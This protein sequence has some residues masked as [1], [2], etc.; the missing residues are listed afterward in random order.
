[1]VLKKKNIIFSVVLFTF[2]VSV[3]FILVWNGVILLNNPSKDKYPV[4]GV[5]VSSYQGKIDWQVLSSQN[6][7]FAFIKATEGSTFVD[8]C[9]A[10]NY[11]EAMKTDLRIGAY[12]FFSFD[13]PGE[14][15]ADNFMATVPITEHML[16]PVVDFEF[17]V[18][19]E[20]NPPEAKAV[21]AQLDDLLEKLETH[22][23]L[24]PILYATDKS[25][26]LYLSGY[27][28]DYDIWIRNVI[29]SASLPDSREWTFWQFTDREKL[30][31]YSGEEK[32]I[33]V[34][35]FYGTVQDFE[36]YAK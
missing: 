26:S 23:G 33:D 11:N 30:Q 22:Y 25:Y 12:H 3:L 28:S 14:T 19:K 9:F 24:K 27:Y 31:G 17:Y 10:Y 36:N 15:Q 1:M 29:S 7:S 21:R 34:N 20:K 16:P 6:I 18:D 13:S 2:T 4:R 8:S 32:Y 35:V 5:D